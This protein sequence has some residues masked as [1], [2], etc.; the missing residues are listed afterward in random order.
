MFGCRRA[1]QM[2][3]YKRDEAHHRTQVDAKSENIAT[4]C[5][6][7]I[8]PVPEVGARHGVLAHA[9]QRQD[10]C[11]KVVHQWSDENVAIRAVEN[12]AMSREELSAVFP[13]HIAFEGACSEVAEE[14]D[15]ADGDAVESTRERPHG[16]SEEK[17]AQHGDGGGAE[18]ASDSAF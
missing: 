6:Y 9:K 17:G 10:Q 4:K 18:E 16:P 3:L 5:L 8:A 13:S 14:S 7:G 1:S 12:T 11:G 15:D 2:C